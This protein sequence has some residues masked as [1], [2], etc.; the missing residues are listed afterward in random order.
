MNATNPT[1]PQSFSLSNLHATPLV[2]YYQAI[3]ASA[4]QGCIG[5]AACRHRLMAEAHDLLALAQLSGRLL[6]H[7]LDLSVGLRAKVELAVPVPCL[8]IRLARCK[9]HRAPCS[10]C[11]IRRRRCSHRSRV[12]P[13]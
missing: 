2:G 5:P 11:S 1:S 10:V 8:P 12:M 6:V 7:W 13:S 3:L 4:Q 9:S